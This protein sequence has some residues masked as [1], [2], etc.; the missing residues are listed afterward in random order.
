[1]YWQGTKMNIFERLQSTD[2]ADLVEALYE[3]GGT[4]ETEISPSLLFRLGELLNHI[5]PEIRE[6][7]AASTGIRLRL[8]QMYPLFMARLKIEQDPNVLCALI[9]AIVA[10]SLPRTGKRRELTL[11]LADFLLNERSDDAVRGV[12]YLGLLKL[13][14]KI[15]PRDYAAA[16]RKLSEMNWNAELIDDLLSTK[17]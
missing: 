14:G 12:A 7:A 16:P 4:K 6:E 2:S 11:R 9:D 10:V 8:P 17:E 1:M 5:H 3:L 13:W 15:A